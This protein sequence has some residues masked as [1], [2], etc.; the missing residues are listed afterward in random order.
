[1][2]GF[3]D[4]RKQSKKNLKLVV[5][6]MCM[7]KSPFNFFGIKQIEYI[8][9][10]VYGPLADYCIQ[11]RKIFNQKFSEKQSSYLQNIIYNIIEKIVYRSALK[12]KELSQKGTIDYLPIKASRSGN[13]ISG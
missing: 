13:K 12:M 6:K 8:G 4:Q 11:N 2:A 5:K 1:M 9:A 7:K 3:L 10:S